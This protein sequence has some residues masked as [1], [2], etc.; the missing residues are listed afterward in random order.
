MEEKHKLRIK[1]IKEN[2]VLPKK[3]QQRDGTFMQG[4]HLNL[5]MHKYSVYS[6]QVDR[7]RRSH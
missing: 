1:T 7:Q 4:I 5:K 3:C 2:Y 6:A